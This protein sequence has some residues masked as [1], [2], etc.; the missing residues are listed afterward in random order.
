MVRQTLVSDKYGTA[1]GLFEIRFKVTLPKRV[2]LTRKLCKEFNDIMAES[3][4]SGRQRNNDM[5]VLFEQHFQVRLPTPPDNTFILYEEW[6]AFEK[7]I[8]GL[9][10]ENG[11]NHH[12]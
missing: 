2:H 12:R 5:K 9:L 11:G 7:E 8:D 1:I 6:V 4:I 3:V 10:P